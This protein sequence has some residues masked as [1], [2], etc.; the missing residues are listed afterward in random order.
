MDKYLIFIQAAKGIKNVLKRDSINMITDLITSPTSLCDHQEEV[1]N[2]GI[3]YLHE[4]HIFFSNFIAVH[5]TL[6]QTRLHKTKLIIICRLITW[7]QRFDCIS[8]RLLNC[9]R[10]MMYIVLF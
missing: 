9:V 4:I 3:C 2:V 10:K 7:R 8:Q 5:C 6:I 1:F